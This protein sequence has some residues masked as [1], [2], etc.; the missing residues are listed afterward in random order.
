MRAWPALLVSG[1]SRTDV[2]RSELFQ[3]ALVDFDVAALDETSDERW[4]VFFHAADE[5]DRALTALRRDF[6][7]LTLEPVDVPDEDWAARS[8]ANLK[9]IRVAPPWDEPSEA[10]PG[11]NR[12][13]TIIIQPSMGFG[14][15]HHATTRLCL[16]ALQRLELHGKTVLDVGTGSG[17]LAIAARMLGAADVLGIDDDADAIESARESVALN[18][19][20]HIELQVVDLKKVALTPFD[21]VLANLTGGLLMQAADRLQELTAATGRL[22]LSG[23]MYTEEIGVLAACRG[24]SVVDREQEDEWM[25]VTLQREGA[26]A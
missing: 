7:D 1:F 21:V 14:T 9:A 11:S 25:C 15:G 6:T 4:R 23:F 20:V 19:G 2:S 18:P 17:V 13:T 3:A 5:R 10:G 12:P 24:F 16:A 8:Q 22:I 26:F